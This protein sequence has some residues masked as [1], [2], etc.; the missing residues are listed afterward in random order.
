MQK[1]ILIICRNHLAKAPRFMME[2]NALKASYKIIAAGESFDAGEHDFKFIDINVHK[3]SK[4][5]N[6]DFFKNYHVFL[7]KIISAF[8]VVI[9]FRSIYRVKNRLK[10][11]FRLLKRKPFDLIIVHH[12]TDLA[13]AVKLAKYKKVKLV[14]NAHE[15]YPLEH[16]DDKVWMKDEHPKLMH[17]AKTLLKDVDMCFCVGSIIAEKYKKEFNL[18]SLVVTNAKPFYDLNPSLIIKG[19]KIKLIHHGAVVRARRIELM[20][21][22]MDHLSDDYHLTLILILSGD[23][24]YFEYLRKRAETNSRVSLVAPVAV[25]EIPRVINRYDI[26]LFILPPSNFNYEY[27]LPNKFFEFVQAR[28]AIAIS[29]SPEMANL[30]NKFDLGLVAEDFTAQAMA[31]KIKELSIEKIMYYKNQAHKYAK[32]LSV[33]N[34]EMLIKNSVDKLLN[35]I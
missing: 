21:E 14:F 7:R 6:I 31:K 32:D 20:I 24:N 17:I 30:V 13:L 19:E 8:I 33:E 10:A 3:K 1:T 9:Y 5:I 35:K 11:E 18:D 23:E 15:Y 34:N 28:L 27:A 25:S 4:K 22:M 2:V 12:F 16:S 26:G 29:P